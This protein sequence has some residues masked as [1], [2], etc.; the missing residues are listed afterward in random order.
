MWVVS[1]MATKY[2]GIELQQRT[3]VEHVLGF[4]LAIWGILLYS[5]LLSTMTYQLSSSGFAPF[6]SYY[7]GWSGF[8]SVLFAVL[9]SGAAFCVITDMLVLFCFFLVIVWIGVSGSVY[10]FCVGG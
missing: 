9:F 6:G 10:W 3:W 4:S 2:F 7:L 5:R 1:N 8:L